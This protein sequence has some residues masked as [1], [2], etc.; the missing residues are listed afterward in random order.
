MRI[1]TRIIELMNSKKTPTDSIEHPLQQTPEIKQIPPVVKELNP[2][3]P[4]VGLTIDSPNEITAEKPQGKT[5]KAFVIESRKEN[6]NYECLEFLHKLGFK[7]VSIP[8]QDRYQQPFEQRL[9]GHDDVSFAVIILSGEEFAYPKDGKPKDAKMQAA[10]VAVFELG[11]LLSRFGKNN[12]LVLYYEQT[13]FLL[14][15]DY[16]NVVYTPYNPSGEW[17]KILLSR[18]RL[19]GFDIDEKKDYLRDYV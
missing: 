3:L 2:V 1:L 18:L 12:T 10:P 6:V 17:R 8:P 9:Q 7:T 13:S 15:T 16:L 5:K 4:A 19:A 14:P 11:F